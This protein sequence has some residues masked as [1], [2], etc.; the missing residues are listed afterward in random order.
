MKKGDVVCKE[1]VYICNMSTNQ[2]SKV[3]INSVLGMKFMIDLV[4]FG[5]E[6]QP[7]DFFLDQ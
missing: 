5:D 2:S 4:V 3:L 6:V 7:T 1:P